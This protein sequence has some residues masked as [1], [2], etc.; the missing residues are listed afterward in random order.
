MKK[1]I[2]YPKVENIAL[3][4]VQET[5]KEG[6]ECWN[7]YVLNLKGTPIS[8]ILITSK[9]Y[10]QIAGEQRNTSVLRHYIETLAPQSY[11]LIEPIVEEVFSL[12]NEYW[13]SFYIG[14]VV[15]DKKYVFLAETIQAQFFTHIPLLNKPGV[16]IH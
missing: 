7:V 12:H 9:G 2:E 16:M 1:D 3:A 5:G 11:A 10:G 15:Y 13:I 6:H 4:I 14:E 8:N